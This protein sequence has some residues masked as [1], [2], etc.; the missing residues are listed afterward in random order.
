MNQFAFLLVVCLANL[1]AGFVGTTLFL[2]CTHT[3]NAHR[4]DD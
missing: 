3:Q 4:A 1:T 2:R